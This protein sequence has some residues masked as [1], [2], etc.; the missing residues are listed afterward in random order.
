MEKEDLAPRALVVGAPATAV[1]T[2]DITTFMMDLGAM[3]FRRAP[4]GIAY[5]RNRARHTWPT[6]VGF[7]FGCSLGALLEAVI[8][9][10]SLTLPVG[11]AFLALALDFSVKQ[12]V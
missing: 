1:M 6:I 9:P 5:A 2:T 11:F 7:T 12:R 4:N 8:G 3:V 10:W